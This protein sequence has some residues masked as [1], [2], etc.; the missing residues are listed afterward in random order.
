MGNAVSAMVSTT[1]AKTDA[2]SNYDVFFFQQVRKM[3]INICACMHD[4][5][6]KVFSAMASS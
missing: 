6:W 1:S 3:N 5:Y 4:M 2:K